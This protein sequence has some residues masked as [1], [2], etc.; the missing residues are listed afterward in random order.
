MSKNWYIK[1]YIKNK[2]SL[3]SIG[4]ELGVT[5]SAIMYRMRKLGIKRRSSYEAL[6][7]DLKGR[8]FGYITVLSHVSRLNRGAYW[9]CRCN[10]PCGGT[11]KE[12]RGS[13]LRNREYVSCGKHK[14]RG[15]YKEISQS[16]LSS[17]KK[18]AKN[19][20][21]SF[22]ITPEYIWNLFLKQNKQCFLSG[23]LIGFLNEQTASL[24]RI[25]SSKGYIV[26]NVQWLHKIVN[27]LKWSLGQ[28]EFI[29]WCKLV[30]N[31][32]DNYA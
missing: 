20:G 2:R 5:A 30:A 10:C 26:G 32:K 11:L 8:K 31:K 15:G 4:T 16:Y 12:I 23:I 27:R 19:K 24:D 1:E 14:D 28:K 17:I 22:E 13:A 7:D 18:R 9:L 21:L 29:M 3:K 6:I 25:D